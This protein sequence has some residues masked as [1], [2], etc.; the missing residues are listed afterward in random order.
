MAL[1]ALLL[2]PTRVT[3]SSDGI[4]QHLP[5]SQWHVKWE[6]IAEWRYDQSGAQT[7][8]GDL[9]NRTKG[10]WHGNRFWIRDKAG[11]KYYLKSWLVFGHRSKQV[12]DILRDRKIEG[13]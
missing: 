13:G 12:A 4:S 8:Q 11:K 9:R 2:L 1:Y 5:R 3:I 7:E 6:D 10:R